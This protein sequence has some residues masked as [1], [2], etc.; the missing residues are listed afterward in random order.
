MKKRSR[1]LTNF[2]Q[3]TKLSL[4][5]VIQR[6][7]PWIASTGTTPIKSCQPSSTKQEPGRN[8]C[9]HVQ[10]FHPWTSFKSCKKCLN[11][12]NKIE[13]VKKTDRRLEP[14]FCLKA[15]SKFMDSGSSE[16]ESIWDSYKALTL[17]YLLGF[18]IWYS[19]ACRNTHTE[20]ISFLFLSI[21]IQL[22]MTKWPYYLG[23]V[24]T[25]VD[26]QYMLA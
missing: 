7:P 1:F 6:A 19:Q 5:L 20:I 10:K 3:Q 13:W 22:I 11:Y 17:I 21:Y 24:P 2:A 8:V 14:T 4:T 25:T 23:T 9:M 18:F 12:Y 26:L 15:M 16:D